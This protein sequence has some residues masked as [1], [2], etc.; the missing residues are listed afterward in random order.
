VFGPDET[1]PAAAAPTGDGRW[2]A[3]ETTR[4]HAY[5]V[6]SLLT[7]ARTEEMRALSWDRVDL[8]GAPYADRTAVRRGFRRVLR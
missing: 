3:A 1:E 8:D 6:V 7:G 4:M 5:I 2:S